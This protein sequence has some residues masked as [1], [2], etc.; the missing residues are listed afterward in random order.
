MVADDGGDGDVVADEDGG[1]DEGNVHH[2]AIGGDAVLTK[3]THELEVVADADDVHG[4]ITHIFAQSV[5]AGFADIGPQDAH[6]GHEHQ[7]ATTRTAGTEIEHRIESA[8]KLCHRGGYGGA[9]HAPSET[10][11]QKSVEQNVDH[12]AD[13]G[14]EGAQLRPLGSHIERLESH[15]QDKAG[16]A[17]HA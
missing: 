12:A 4:N 6:F 2:Y 3:E 13:H 10:P 1:I 15:L 5:G 17:Y 7:R 8:H 9:G 16:K 14:H 11:H